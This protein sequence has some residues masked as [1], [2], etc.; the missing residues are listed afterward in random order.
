MITLGIDIGGSTTKAAGFD[1]NGKY[2]GAVQVRAGDRLTSAYGAIG[3][4]IFENNIPLSDV[5]QIAV[6]GVGS[7]QIKHDIYGIPTRP[8]DE[9]VAVGT[10]GL[11][12]SGQKRA[13]IASLGTGTAFVRADGAEIKHLGGSGVGGGML[14]GMC[15][16][17]FNISSFETIVRLS[18]KGDLHNVDLMIKDISDDIIPTLPP[19]TT[20]ANF[21]KL[22]DGAEKEDVVLGI[23]NTILQTA[24]VMASFLCKNDTIDTVVAVGALTE[25]PQAREIFKAFKKLM[26]I[27]FLIPSEAIYATAIGAALTLLR[28]E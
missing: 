9:F 3:R 16:Y 27:N 8:V 11:E 25:L 23:V 10:G 24:G 6:T 21:G 2:I 26:G 20:A 15:K 19:E 13:I 18:E 5:D 4:F 7:S 28:H 12:L 14:T 1:R 17:M 22:S